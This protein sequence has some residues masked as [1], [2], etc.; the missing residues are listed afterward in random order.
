MRN[1]RETREKPCTLGEL[2]G[3]P[4]VY[5]APE[6][7]PGEGG[8]GER[9]EG[10]REWEYGSGGRQK[11]KNDQP[12]SWRNKVKKSSY[13]CGT[14]W[15]KNRLHACCSWQEPA[16]RS[17]QRTGAGIRVT[18]NHFKQVAPGWGKRNEQV[19]KCKQ[20]APGWRKRNEQ[21]NKCKQVQ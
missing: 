15:H 7:G 16:P 20:V 14:E 6:D 8:P 18:F 5:R 10:V 11:K 12:R 19:N 3:P 2:G 1:P 13:G 17:P 4:V 9:G 21:V